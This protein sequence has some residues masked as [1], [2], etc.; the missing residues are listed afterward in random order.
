MSELNNDQQER[1]LRL[2]RITIAE[3]LGVRT[4]LERPELNDDLFNEERGAFVTLHMQGQLRGCIGYIVGVKKIPDAVE[5]MALAAAFRD[6]RFRPLGKDEYPRI[7]LEISVLSPIEAVRD[8]SEIKVGRDGIIISRGFHSGL[9]LPQVAVEYGWDLET[10]LEHT[11]YK[12]GLPGNAW[13]QEGTK[14]EKFSAQVFGE[15]GSGPK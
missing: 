11:C 8:I 1:L 15:K 14:I 5:E 13:K 12:A 10:F 9:L 4:G 2:A 3:R 6:P 7:D